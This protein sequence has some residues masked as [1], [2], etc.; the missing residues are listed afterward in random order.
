MRAIP[1][2]LRGVFTTRRYTN[3]RLPLPLQCIW[4]CHDDSIIA[5][6]PGSSDERKTAPSAE[7]LLR[8]SQL[9]CAVNPVAMVYIRR[10]HLLLLSWKAD[11]H[12]AIPRSLE[13]DVISSVMMSSE[14]A[15]NAA[16]HSIRR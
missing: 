5:R 13:G 12:F 2:R 16:L 3:P 14:R 9:T 1:E 10:C 6:A 15:I 4:C 7:Q 11:I 8:P